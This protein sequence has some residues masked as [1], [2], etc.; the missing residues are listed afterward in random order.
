MAAKTSGRG[1]S[2]GAARNAGR[3]KALSSLRLPPAKTSDPRVKA[4]QE[5]SQKRLGYVRNFL[6]L[7]FGPDRLALYQGYIDRL[8]RSDD[9]VLPA[10]ERELLALVVSAENRCEVCVISHAIALERLGVPR[11]TVDI[12]SLAWRRADITPREKALAEFA[13]RLTAHAAEADDSYLEGLRAAGLKENEIMEAAQIVAIFNANN[14][15]NSV[16]GL[17]VNPEAHDDYRAR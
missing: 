13:W 3:D 16:I 4:L 15:F 8:M 9:A 10:R 11:R 6:Q 14:R 2:R 7:P 1:K 5:A 12:L 17:R